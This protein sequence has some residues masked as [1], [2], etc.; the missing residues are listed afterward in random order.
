[1]SPLKE[2]DFERALF[3]QTEKEHIAADFDHEV[4]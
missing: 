1:M 4:K 2:F 3:L